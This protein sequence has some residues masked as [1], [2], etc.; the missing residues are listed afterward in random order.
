[1]YISVLANYKRVCYVTNWAQYRNGAG[2]YQ[3]KDVDPFLCTHVIYAFAKVQGNTIQPYEWNDKPD[4]GKS[5]SSNS[6]T[7]IQ[8]N[9]TGVSQFLLIHLQ[10]YR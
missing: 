5:I 3:V 10:T 8:I 6:F 2:K 7:N 1:M 9:L 4:W